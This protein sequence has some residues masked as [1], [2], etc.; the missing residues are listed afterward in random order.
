MMLRSVLFIYSAT[1]AESCFSGDSVG[2]SLPVQRI[3]NYVHGYTRNLYVEYSAS[4]M[5]TYTVV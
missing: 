4:M 5:Y 2:E 3:Y 1:C